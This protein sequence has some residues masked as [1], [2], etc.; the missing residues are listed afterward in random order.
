MA[1]AASRKILSEFIELYKNSPCLWFVKSRD[2]NNRAK[3][4][5]AYTKLLNKYRELK[6]TADKTAVLKKIS[7]IRTVYRKE[8]AKV[9]KSKKSGAVGDQVY[10]PMLWYF[11]LMSFLDDQGTIRKKKSA[12]KEETQ[13]DVSKINFLLI[14]KYMLIVVD[15][16]SL[17]HVAAATTPQWRE[18]F[19]TTY[20][21]I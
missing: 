4:E 12:I 1:D 3:K 18:T 20:A 9:E 8:V 15:K 2:Y 5:L 19:Q 13:Q 7:G 6:S 16:T 11:D 21:P 14:P 17:S 10:I